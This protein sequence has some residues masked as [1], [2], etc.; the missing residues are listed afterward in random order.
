MKA[1]ILESGVAGYQE[2]ICDNSSIFA[3]FG[4][5]VTYPAKEEDEEEFE[6]EE[7]EE[8]DDYAFL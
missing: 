6:E 4:G 1:W 8:G 2:N 5:C 7:V 3:P